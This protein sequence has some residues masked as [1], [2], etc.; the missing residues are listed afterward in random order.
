[1]KAYLVRDRIRGTLWGKGPTT[2]DPTGVRMVKPYDSIK[3]AKLGRA[4]VWVPDT[5]KPYTYSGKQYYSNK[6]GKDDC[7]IVEIDISVV[8]GNTV[9]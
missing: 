9:G 4:N 1:M 7:D 6:P 3:N 2:F 5:T 8:I